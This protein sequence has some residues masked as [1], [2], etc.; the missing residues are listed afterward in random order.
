MFARSSVGTGNVQRGDWECVKKILH[1]KMKQKQA[2][3]HGETLAGTNEFA[4]L[5]VKGVSDKQVL[6]SYIID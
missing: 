1:A 2:R 5:S 4:G 3:K 6:C